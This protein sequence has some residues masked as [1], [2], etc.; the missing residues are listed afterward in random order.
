MLS[1]S[2]CDVPADETPASQFPPA[3]PAAQSTG[4]AYTGQMGIYTIDIPWGWS[5]VDGGGSADAAFAPPGGK[6]YGSIFVGVEYTRRS[7]EAETEYVAG[8]NSIE[9]RRR[10]SIGGMPCITFASTGSRG[11]RDNDLACQVVVPFQDGTRRIT[12]FMGSASR[13]W[14]YA[15]QT[16]L[17][18]QMVNSLTWGNDVIAD[19]DARDDSED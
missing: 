14:E 5:E 7:L 15:E 4:G 6:A 3:A 12:F 19:S 9:G 1:A 18:W 17:F 2:S 13:P 8:A 10:L 11:E 16:N